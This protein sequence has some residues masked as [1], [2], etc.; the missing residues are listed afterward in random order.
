MFTVHIPEEIRTYKEKVFWQLT[1]T[2]LV[3][4]IVAFMICVPLYIFGRKYINEDILS[5][6]V[7]IIGVFIICMGFV[8]IHGMSFRIFL[9]NVFKSVVL[10]PHKRKFKTENFIRSILEEAEKEEQREISLVKMKKYKKQAGLEKA[11][12]L[13]QAEKYGVEVNLQTLDDNL[14]TVRKP[15][16]KKKKNKVSQEKSR[17]NNKKLEKLKEQS[18]KIENKKKDNPLYVPSK[19]ER[20]VL[21]AYIKERNNQMKKEIESGKKKV[22]KKVSLMEK[23][24]NAKSNLPKSAQDTIPYIAEYEEGLLEV[25]PNLYS[26]TFEFSDINYLDANDE[27]Q[28][29]IFEKWGEFLSY[30]PEDIY[31]EVSIDN[32]I[33]SVNEQKQ[34]I[35]YKL[36]GD[37]NDIHREE[38]NRIMQRQ[39][40]AGRND[41]KKFKYIT[42]SM[43]SD[44]AYEAL[45][46]FQRLE[47]EITLK[48]KE[49][50][51]DIKLQVCSTEKRLELLHDKFRPG[52]EGDFGVL[53]N[54]FQEKEINFYK[55]LE[56]QGLSAKDYI[57]PSSFTF[58]GENYYEIGVGERYGRCL[59]LNNLPATLMTD[60]FSK[61][62]DVD[63]PLLTSLHYQSIPKDKGIKMIRR[64][65]TSMEKNMQ[66]SQKDAIRNGFNPDL[67]INHD[68]KQKY[69]EA[70]KLFDFCTNKNQ[71][72][73]FVTI[74]FMITADSKD[75]LDTYTDELV[76][77]ARQY[78]CQIQKFDFQQEDAFKVIL[79][80]GIMP[81]KKLYVDRTLPTESAAIF[82]PFE[83]QELFQEGGFYY[84]LN[85]NTLNM[86]LCDRTKM[87]KTPSGFILGSTG[88][89]KSFAAKREMINVLLQNDKNNLFVIDPENEYGSF[90]RAFGASILTF[91]GGSDLHTNPLDMNENYGLDD[92]DDPETTPMEKKKSKALKKKVDYLMSII[93]FMVSSEKDNFEIKSTQKT[94]I[95]RAIRRT[96]ENFLEH[97]FDPQYQPTFK[98][99]QN[100]LDKEKL[101]DNGTLNQEG[102]HIAE[103]CE[104]YTRGSMD[105]F[106]YKTNVDLNNRFIIFNI[107]DLPKELRQISLLIILDFV[108]N[109]L[110]KNANKVIRTYCYV[111]EV[112]EL[113]K[114]LL[115]ATYLEQLYSR[116]RKYGLI[117]TG[118]TQDVQTI[119]ASDKGRKMLNNSD[120]I[121]MLNQKK[122]NLDKLAEL[123]EISD[124]QREYVNNSDPG[125]GLLFAEKV[126]VPFVDHFPEDSYL[127]TLISTKFDEKGM[128]S[129]EEIREYVNKLRRQQKIKEN[130]KIQM[131]E[132]VV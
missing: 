85:P 28:E 22:K 82:T 30:F 98:D 69:A 25:E 35:L 130:S 87:Q 29:R 41:I 66:E 131:L 56:T 15:M 59:F 38:Y 122:E 14:L 37:N 115:S 55:F 64:Q 31:V 43:K 126:I 52:N 112:Q 107:R 21:K 58:G 19:I 62:I 102:I 132:S 51:R 76:R 17:N 70:E 11:Y 90:G 91:S 61:I 8:T 93:S 119:L 114:N 78:T 84:G 40:M 79:P 94:I 118:I 71:R 13:E 2:Q 97:D 36:T 124:S 42:I 81:D 4:A 12:M 63:F 10:L 88:S 34:K 48:I 108:W 99:L 50:H 105:L 103:S 45:L 24:R 125:S 128:M 67:G 57:A 26:K 129:D 80:L 60:N 68:T 54:E 127:Y 121:I 120:F 77:N 46:K 72:L 27:E 117:I 23:R 39:M 32:R 20:L 110:L 109:Q 96:Y 100:E 9:K 104:Y 3:S 111:D 53:L 33:I 83:Y 65:L 44:N 86:I 18:E 106:S 49:I 74:G 6:I 47:K 5:W 73:F 1:F 16:S 116:G 101:R 95:D 92:K 113:L 7:L 75:K 89:G 123:L